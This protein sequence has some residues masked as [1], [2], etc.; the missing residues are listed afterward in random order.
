[1]RIIFVFDNGK[2]LYWIERRALY[3]L[4]RKDGLI[5]WRFVRRIVPAFDKLELRTL[6]IYRL[7]LSCGRLFPHCISYEDQHLQENPQC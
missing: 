2:D 3:E 1:M 4:D 6:P 7:D 5:V